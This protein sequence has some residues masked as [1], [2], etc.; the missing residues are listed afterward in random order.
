M[1]QKTADVSFSDREIE[2]IRRVALERGISEDEATNELAHEAIAKRFK[3]RLGRQ[4][5]T[6][7]PLRAR[8]IS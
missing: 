2:V 7:Y 6:V 3:Q 8:S 5:A 4:P 1:N